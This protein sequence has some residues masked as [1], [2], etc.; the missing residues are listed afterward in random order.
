MN[1]RLDRVVSFCYFASQVLSRLITAVVFR[2][3]KISNNHRR[4]E[5]QQQEQRNRTEKKKRKANAVAAHKAVAD[6]L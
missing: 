3:K 5:R 6:L 1:E 2:R 4:Q